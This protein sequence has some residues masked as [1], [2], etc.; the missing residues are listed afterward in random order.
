MTAKIT[1]LLEHYF[2][3][4]AQEEP[5]EPA[6]EM[7]PDQIGL[8]MRAGEPPPDATFD[9]YLPPEMRAVSGTYWTPLVVAARAAEWLDGLGVRTVVDIGSG[10]GKFC[11][12]AAISGKGHFVGVEHRPRLVEAARQLARSFDVSSRVSFVEDALGEGPMPAA[13]AYYLYNPYGENLFW[14]G[15]RLDDDVELSEPRF[16]RDVAATEALFASVPLGTYVVTYNGF[17]GRMPSDYAA[18]RVDRTLPNMLRLWQK[19]VT[20]RS[21]P[22][23]LDGD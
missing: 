5:E 2:I 19:T 15:E 23:P 7:S 11:V 9:R 8:A 13:D 12:A 6:V 18:L 14:Y 20:A 17:G 21:R 10:A 1:S 22:A 3:A 4:R 16:A